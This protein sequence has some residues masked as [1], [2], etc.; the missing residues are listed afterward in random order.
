MASEPTSQR[1]KRVLAGIQDGEEVV[2]KL[3]DGRELF[4]DFAGLWIR[5]APGADRII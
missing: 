2:I 5:S 3:K 4:W 1:I